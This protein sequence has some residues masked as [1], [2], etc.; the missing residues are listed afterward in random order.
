MYV[1]TLDGKV[2]ALDLTKSGEVKWSVDTGTPLLSSSI[3]K[4]DLTSNGKWVRL[5]PSLSGGLYKFD[6]ENIEAIPIK[7]EDLLRSSFK[8]SDDIVMSGGMETRSYGVSAK[9]GKILYECSINGCQNFTHSTQPI[10][11]KEHNP[12]LD[13]VLILRR[14]T[15]TVRA[16]E[17]REGVERWNFSIGIHQMEMLKSK[18][19]QG[20]SS[21]SEFDIFLADL[22]FKAVVPEGIVCAFSK[23]NPGQM[24]W[25]HQFEFPI[26]SAWKSDGSVSIEHVDFFSGADW[27]W[28]SGGHSQANSLVSPSLYLGMYDKQ[29][30]IQESEQRRALAAVSSHHSPTKLI[31]DDTDFQKIPFRPF[32]ATRNAIDLIEDRSEET[33]E[34]MAVVPAEPTALA[35]SVSN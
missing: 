25:M 21:A 12:T 9:N 6:G 29:P 18:D 1:S 10:G 28:Q 3:H 31:S 8:F 23:S 22:E 4:L 11:P 24:M 17:P 13:D 7:A 33:Q 30:Y 19:C 14:E 32:P 26:V 35:N 27:L 34:E 16:I 5:I 2:S 15:Q 20:S